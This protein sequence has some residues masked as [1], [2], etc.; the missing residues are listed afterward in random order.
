MIYYAW[1]LQKGG[2]CPMEDSATPGHPF[3]K[4][5]LV[6]GG[7]KVLI[8]PTRDAA[9]AYLPYAPAPCDI[10]ALVG[11]PTVW[12]DGPAWIA[13]AKQKAIVGGRVLVQ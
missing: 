8:F 2:R 12:T 4:G 13:E 11:L 3:R 1:A 10:V 7:G 9:F 6:R 5:D